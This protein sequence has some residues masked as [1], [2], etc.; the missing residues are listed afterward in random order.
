M[1]GART[2]DTL[3]GI[4]ED[5]IV[6]TL[7]YTQLNEQKEA[8]PVLTAYLEFPSLP[9]SS[10]PI[11]EEKSCAKR[12]HRKQTL[13]VCTSATSRAL[14]AYSQNY[15]NLLVYILASKAKETKWRVAIRPTQ[16]SAIRNYRQRFFFTNA[17]T[18]YRSP[19]VLKTK[20]LIL[21]T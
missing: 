5:E 13:S 1:Q 19:M 14:S 15:G 4:F 9:S 7:N 8:T 18:G 3:H 21:R 11:N 17:E 2:L 16:H 6:Q 12:G 10:S 20:P